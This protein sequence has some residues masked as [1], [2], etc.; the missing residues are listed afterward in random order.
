MFCTNCGK[1]IDDDSKF[2]EFCGVKSDANSSNISRSIHQANFISS[3]TQMQYPEQARAKKSPLLWVILFL[4]IVLA[5]AVALLGVVYFQNKQTNDSVQTNLESTSVQETIMQETAETTDATITTEAVEAIE[6]TET[7]EENLE[8]ALAFIITL[9]PDEAPVTCE[10]F[11]YLVESGFYDGLTFHRV[12]DDFMVQGGDPNGDGT[13]GSSE[14]ILGEF[15]ENGIENDLSHT[16]GVV[17]MA[18]GTD[19]NSASSQFFICYTDCSYLDG[20]YAAFGK[21]TSGMEVVDAFQDVARTYNS[22][23]ELAVPLTEIVIQS[24]EMIKPDT[25]GNPRVLFTMEDFLN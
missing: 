12:V 25:N 23:G 19:Y 13:G 4:C 7:E 15:Y 11:E 21:V 3:P 22:V 5:A 8:S 16:R 1:E 20:T 10:N 14:M 9:Y 6:T 18:R 17:S 2:C 24:A